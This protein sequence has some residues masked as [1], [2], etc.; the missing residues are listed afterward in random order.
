[1][2]TQYNVITQGNLTNTNG[3]LSGFSL[4]DYAT[5]TN[6]FT[7]SSSTFEIVF[8]F[9]LNSID[10][11]E[12]TFPTIMASSNTLTDWDGY[13]FQVYKGCLYLEIAQNDEAIMT[14]TDETKVLSANTDYWAKATFDGSKYTIYISTNGTT[15]TEQASTTSSSYY[16]GGTINTTYL[17]RQNVTEDSNAVFNGTIDLNESYIKVGGQYLWRGVTN[18]TTIQLRRDTASNW[19]TVNPILAEGEVGIE[20]DTR[21]QKFGDGSTAWNSLAYSYGDANGNFDGQWSNVTATNI[22]NGSN[23]TWSSGHNYDLS[24]Y[25]PNDGQV[26]EVIFTASWTGSTAGSNHELRASTDII[27]SAWNWLG[28]ASGTTPT[29]GTCI[30]PVGSGRYVKLTTAAKACNAVYFSALGYRRLGTNS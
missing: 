9:K 14:V 26:Y 20:T 17:G 2:T 18:T 10:T 5:L 28:R 30:L 24:T 3:V 21:K 23:I 11:S 1:M 16:T 27:T 6:K 8:K 12:D 25:L 4:S 7:P 29:F 19:S 15:Y 13:N 22:I